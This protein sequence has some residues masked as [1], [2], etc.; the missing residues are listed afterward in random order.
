MMREGVTI[1]YM[2]EATNQPL[3]VA[4]SHQ[5]DQTE[6]LPIAEIKAMLTEVL[7]KIPGR[8]VISANRPP[9]SFAKIPISDK[10]GRFLL[11]RKPMSPGGLVTVF[12]ELAPYADKLAWAGY[13][14]DISDVEPEAIE[15]IMRS[16]PN[17][18]G[19]E[20]VALIPVDMSPDVFKGYYNDFANNLWFPLH[21]GLLINNADFNQMKAALPS[22]KEGNK[23]FAQAYFQNLTEN[24]FLWDNDYHHLLGAKYLRE[25]NAQAGR[26]DPK[27][28]M[29]IHTPMSTPEEFEQLKEGLGEK[30]SIELLEGLLYYDIVGF[31]SNR[32]RDKYINCLRAN[33]QHFSGL[34]IGEEDVDGGIT[35]QYQGRKILIKKYAV[36][37]DPDAWEKKGQD[38]EVAV[39][40]QHLSESVRHWKQDSSD[41]DPK[42]KEGKVM[43]DDNVMHVGR[44]DR[45]EPTK[46]YWHGAKAFS[47]LL[48]KHPELIGLVQY[49]MAGSTASRMDNPVYQHQLK[50]MQEWTR[51]MNNR[52]RKLSGNEELSVA[53]L[54]L[55]GLYGNDLLSFYKGLDLLDIP[56]VA[57]GTNLVIQE[58]ALVGAKTVAIGANTGAAENIPAMVSYDP[59]DYQGHAEI[60]Y[61]LLT[62]KPQDRAAYMKRVVEQIRKHNVHQYAYRFLRDAADLYQQAA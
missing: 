31:S 29:Y 10:P 34:Q 49:L 52:A 17:G 47:R 20:R 40:A 9:N 54:A 13:I 51:A 44:V 61:Q 59:Y 23:A 16:D 11:E 3:D 2:P 58:G 38:P 33:A 56:A 8:V 32:N 30:E 42:L 37:L 14:G 27:M 25:M 45:F 28:G 50:R 57:D 62:M 1:G 22:Y 12:R 55:N 39:K 4:K 21:G 18:D 6:N 43:V 46:G 36:G 41:E 35:I 24:D 7:D 5:A 15:E 48:R 26:K 19:I 53:V 60:M